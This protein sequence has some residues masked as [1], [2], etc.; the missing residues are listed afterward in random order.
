MSY[1]HILLK[2]IFELEKKIQ[3]AQGDKVQLEKELQRLKLA[4]LVGR[5]LRSRFGEDI[6]ETDQK[7]LKG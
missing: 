1:R 4:E 5:R 3:E 7:L 2:Q 6:R